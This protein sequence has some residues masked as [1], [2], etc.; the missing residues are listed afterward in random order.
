MGL[1]GKK[2][3]KLIDK[4]FQLKITFRIIGITSIGFL[5]LIAFLGVHA[6]KTINDLNKTIKTE[7]DMVK[8]FI[9][10]ND[11]TKKII[12]KLQPD[13]W[14]EI[15]IKKMTKDHESAMDAIRNQMFSLKIFISLLIGIVLLQAIFLYFYLVD[16]TH[17]ISGPLFV[18]SQQI[19]LML[20]GKKPNLRALRKN[21]EL[22]EFYD[23]F[24]KLVD[25]MHDDKS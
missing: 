8:G 3:Q 20:K 4:K 23:N 14:R 15:D 25:K 5:I 13:E 7:D 16:M 21:D 24:T 9:K 6:T 11:Y 2:R 22:K 12:T 18:I 19:D 17:K 10:Y 1:F